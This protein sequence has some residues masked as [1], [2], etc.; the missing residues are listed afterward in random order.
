MMDII[1]TPHPDIGAPSLA[2]HATMGPL[3]L[4]AIEM[5]CAPEARGVIVWEVWGGPANTELVASGDAST[6]V[7]AKM[8]AEQA[9]RGKVDPPARLFKPSID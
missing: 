3:E 1:W 5:R 2:E 4:V 9:A 6:F 7:A 8:A